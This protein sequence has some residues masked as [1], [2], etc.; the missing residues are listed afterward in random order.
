MKAP[1]LWT[2]A[3]I[4]RLLELCRIGTPRDIIADQLGWTTHQ[5]VNFDR[6][7]RETNR[8]SYALPFSTT[9]RRSPLAGKEAEIARMSAKGLS[10]KAIAEHFGVT[11]L[12]VCGFMERNG[13]YRRRPYPYR[14]RRQKPKDRKPISLPKICQRP[15]EAFDKRDLRAGHWLARAMEGA[16]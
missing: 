6:W 4:A 10:S 1:F 12:T 11:R 13:L 8:Q 16:E 3:N 5:V 14:P 15:I 9:F 7:L 2:Q